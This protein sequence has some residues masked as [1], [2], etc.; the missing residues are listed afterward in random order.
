M[1]AQLFLVIHHSEVVIVTCAE[2]TVRH[3]LILALTTFDSPD[4][5]PTRFETIPR[6]FASLHQCHCLRE[7][8]FKH[9][10]QRLL[11]LLRQCMGPS[12]LLRELSEN[13]VFS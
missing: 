8:F 3:Y 5:P 7:S 11:L 6:N 9:S 10:G 4:S 12:Y 1:I 2:H 13:P